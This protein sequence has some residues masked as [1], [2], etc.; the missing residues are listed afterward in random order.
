MLRR[1]AKRA[2]NP[3]TTCAEA[4]SIF[5][6]I[7][8]LI[9]YGTTEKQHRL[10]VSL[11]ITAL[12]L[13][14]GQRD[15]TIRKLISLA[16]RH[17]H[18]SARSD[19]L[20][21][22]VLSGE[23][24]DV[25]DVN[26][27]IAETLEAAVKDKWILTQS[28]GWYL[29]VWLQL[30]PF[31]DRPLDSLPVVLGLPTEHRDPYSLRDLVRAFGD[32]PS[33]AEDFL[34]Q[35]GEA[36]PRFYQLHEW[37]D[38]VMALETLSS[39]RRLVDLLANGMLAGKSSDNYHF[40]EQLGS[41]LPVHPDL[42][43]HAYS[44]LKNGASS[45][46]LATLAAAIAQNPDEDGLLLL[47]NCERHGHS[48]HDWRTIENAVTEHVPLDGSNAYSVVPAPAVE[49]RRKLFA[50]TTDGGPQDVAARWLTRIDVVRDEYGLPEGEPRHPDLASGRAWPIM[51]P[52]PEA[53][54]D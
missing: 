15:E 40:V 5:A 38:S 16:P 25:A 35:L 28:N 37:R 29:R 12:R 19:L 36:D 8:R 17:A 13:P 10:A 54:A 21:S 11:G 1:S 6:A 32:S 42:R 26:G 33:Q 46:G 52:D 7:E 24:I 48:F 31:T 47:M 51:T 41:L 27:G 22:L 20:L 44:L 4:E 3:T 53:S 50:M 2:A 39:A 45:K 30:I 18:D 23:E 9:A 34:F 49:L 14:H 43:R